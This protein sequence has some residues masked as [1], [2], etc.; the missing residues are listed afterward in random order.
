MWNVLCLLIGKILIKVGKPF[1]KSTTAPG[2]IVSFLNKKI[3][4]YFKLPKIVIAVTGSS[5]KG[6]TSSMIAEILRKN[7]L[8]VAHNIGGANLTSGILTLLIESSKLNGQLNQDVLICEV[9]ERYTIEVFKII[10]PN[11]VVITNITRDQPPRQGHFDIV[12]E[13]IN[14]AINEDMHLIL[15]ADDPYLQKF[16]IDKKNQITYYGINKN[17]FSYQEKKF[18]NL[19]INYCPQCHNLLEYNYYHF[20][21]NGDYFCSN[22]EFKRPKV[23]YEVTSINYESSNIIINKKYN[24]NLSSDILYTVYNTLASFSVCSLL[25]INKKNIS[26]A[27]SSINQNKKLFHVYPYK[28]RKVIVLNNKNE[29]SSTFN[30]SLLYVSRFKEFKVIVIGWKEISRRYQFDDLSWLYDIDFELLKDMNI[31]KII[32]VGIHRYDIAVRM[33]YSNID[34]DK[35]VLFENLIAATDYI[36]HSTIGN[37]YGILNFDYVSDFNKLMGCDNE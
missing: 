27:I 32:C 16:V 37:V 9:D 3:Y 20:E 6:S 23:D 25:K 36:K 13:K 17:Q 24:I 26:T 22:C 35:I 2:R 33:K 11:Y 1:G 29:N 15:N 28:D 30:Q 7:G 14:S 18:K 34:E 19:N 4:S 10:K 31:E 5:G 8:V 12:F 21:N